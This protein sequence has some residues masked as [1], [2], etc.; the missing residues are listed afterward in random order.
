MQLST[1]SN[2]APDNQNCAIIENDKVVVSLSLKKLSIIKSLSTSPAATYPSC[3][4]HITQQPT[5]VDIFMA[6]WG[7]PTKSGALRLRG[8]SIATSRLGHC[9][10]CGWSIVTSR[11]EHCDFTVGALR[12]HGWGIATRFGAF[13][14][15]GIQAEGHS[16]YNSK[17]LQYSSTFILSRCLSSLMFLTFTVHT[18]YPHFNSC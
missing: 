3:V 18:L 8:W 13:R 7:L 6:H 16:D 5:L 4:P 1:Y 15:W 9:G 14:L 12:L 2:N 10:L 11:L 17:L